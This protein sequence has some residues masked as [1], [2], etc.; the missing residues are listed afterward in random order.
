MRRQSLQVSPPISI[1]PLLLCGRALLREGDVP[2]PICALP[3]SSPRGSPRGGGRRSVACWPAG[4]RGGEAKARR[5]DAG[6]ERIL[7]AFGEKTDLRPRKIHL[8]GAGREFPA[9]RRSVFLGPE[10]SNRTIPSPSR[11]SSALR[12]RRRSAA[13]HKRR[14]RG[15]APEANHEGDEP[16]NAHGSG[17]RLRGSAAHRRSWLL[18]IAE[19]P[20]RL[21][22]CRAALPGFRFRAL[23]VAWCRAGQL[24]STRAKCSRSYSITDTPSPSHHRPQAARVPEQGFKTPRF[25]GTRT[26]HDPYRSSPCLDAQNVQDALGR[27]P[28][29]RRRLRRMDTTARGAALQRRP[30]RPASSPRSRKAVMACRRRAGSSG[31]RVAALRAKSSRRRRTAT[32]RSARALLRSL[33]GPRQPGDALGAYRKFAKGPPTVALAEKVAA[34]RQLARPRPS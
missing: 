12:L 34:Y 14:L 5:Q 3:G 19:R 9:S 22:R 33:S 30:T 13:G 18:R 6:S 26:R 31:L 23:L 1:T 11:S 10:C 16:G 7:F 8:A 28:T 15:R 24:E 25:S 20:A 29:P 21:R 32:R 2:E 4:R 27:E 17:R